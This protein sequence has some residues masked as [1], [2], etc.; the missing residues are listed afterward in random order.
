M[1]TTIPEGKDS[2]T[3]LH[4]SRFLSKQM[5]DASSF[6]G[7][8]VSR[9][10]SMMGTIAKL[11]ADETH[12]TDLT[13]EVCITLLMDLQMVQEAVH[14]Q[15]QPEDVHRTP[16]ANYGRISPKDVIPF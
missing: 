15:S 13:Q 1:P 9:T 3:S 16:P 7:Y 11:M 12:L 10:R 5:Q 2:G 6:E 8:I 4:A 14:R